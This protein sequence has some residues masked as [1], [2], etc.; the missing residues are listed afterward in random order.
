MSTLRFA[1][2]HF[3]RDWKSGE[4]A[5]M[6]MALLV[7]VAALTAIAF[8][9]NRIALGVERQAGEVLAADIR[10]E[11]QQPFNEV[12]VKRAEQWQ[13][14][15]ARL[16]AFPSVVQREDHSALSA[17]SAVSAA[18][19][20]RGR[21]K[22]SRTLDGATEE[23]RHGPGQ[24]E[25]WVDARLLAQLVANIGDRVEIGRAQFTITRVIV[26]RP[27][28]GSQFVQLAPVALFSL[29]ALPSTEL[30]QAGSR[31]SYAL[32]FAGS[33]SSIAEFKRY[34]QANQRPGERITDI[35][36]ASPQLRESMDRAGS[37]LNLAS[38][39]SVLLAAIAVAMA[40]RRYS[41][42]RLDLAALMKSMGATQSRVLAIYLIQLVII[43]LLASVIG[44]LIGFGAQEGL[45]WL[46]S[47]FLRS[48]LPPPTF[49]PA[50][51]GLATAISV[52]IGFAFPP[53]LQLKRVP[54]VRVLRKDIDAPP[55]HYLLIY[56]LAMSAVIAVVA[57]ILRDVSL[58]KQ[59]V[60]GLIAMFAALYFCGWLLV[61]ALSI[62]RGR[63]GVSWRY[64]VANIARR[65]RESVVQI[66]AF[67]LGLMVLLLLLVVR[68]DLLDNWRR[69]L[70]A[71]APNQFLINIQPTQADNVRAFFVAHRLPAPS[72][73]PMASAR[74]TNV[75]DTPFADWMAKQRRGG[76]DDQAANRFR[77][78]AR[79]GRAANLSWSAELP[80]GN[81]VVEG[82]W[83]TANDGGGPRISME[84]DY[85]RNMGV[86]VGDRITYDVSGEAVTATVANLRDVQ[87]SSFRPNYFMVFSPGVIDHAVGTYISSLYVPS[88]QRAT[89]REFMRQ[90]PEV[91]AIDIEA[92]L[93]QIRAVMDKVS[94]A[95]QYVFL[96][97]LFAGITVLFAAI[98]ATRDERRYESAML[99]TLGA[100]RRVVLQGVASEF[101][102]LGMLAGVL[103][104]GGATLVGYLLATGPFN[105]K[106]SFD[107][108]VWTFGLIAGVT[109]VGVIGTLATYSVV[110]APPVA[111]LRK[112]T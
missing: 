73:S 55:L 89:M 25:V 14:S 71:N 78:R 32:L 60:L 51:L 100:S 111:T 103:A 16:V 26:S 81:K 24:G 47:D 69:S 12:H 50:L 43:A 44:T 13:L 5:V 82:Q 46:L 42:R 18:Y 105:L 112:G 31:A 20:L 58:V 106:Y 84:V 39:V 41:A 90:F 2:V 27:D 21:L 110:N 95:V 40:A 62:V 11:S 59:V 107:P 72:L 49:G 35:A 109:L 15:V 61:R 88:A 108:S 45:A 77:E 19:P 63:V 104:A 38:M 94:L 70:P 83:W 37:F 86:K 97:T 23:V 79:F 67:G 56:G 3:A 33:A 68:N 57:A 64:G 9:T 101:L 10:I 34:V 53:L 92:V 22:L 48:E 74:I 87:W 8:F 52:L 65:G 93:S 6:A 7:A 30:I 1:L 66:V 17:V 28:Q 102:V 76:T 29:E 99:R 85:A 96:F 98:Q 54:P 91:T 80:E 4:Q 75:N 36:D